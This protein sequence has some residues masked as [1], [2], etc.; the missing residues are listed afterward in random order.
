[1]YRLNCS[2]QVAKPRCY[3][4]TNWNHNADN[5][6]HRIAIDSSRNVPNGR[7]Q[8]FIAIHNLQLKDTNR[9]NTA[10][11]RLQKFFKPGNTQ[12]VTGNGK[13][14]PHIKDYIPQKFDRIP[15]F[16]HQLLISQGPERETAFLYVRPRSSDGCV[17][18]PYN[19]VYDF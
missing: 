14:P 2:T 10:Q 18:I 11:T 13:R 12:V 17:H 15:N 7:R 4:I 3:S 19:T 8:N 1:M 5:A 16:G 6:R 9:S